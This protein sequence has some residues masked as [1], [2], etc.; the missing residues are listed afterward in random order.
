MERLSNYAASSPEVSDHSLALL[1]L[2]FDANL[3]VD[4]EIL[5]VLPE[6]LQVEAFGKLN[7]A[8]GKVNLDVYTL[9]HTC[10]VVVVVFFSLFHLSC[11]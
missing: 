10:L 1:V 9:S 11:F 5:Q 8:I 7:N 4:Y 6:F 3:L 2:S